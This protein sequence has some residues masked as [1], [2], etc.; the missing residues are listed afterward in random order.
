MSRVKDEHWETL[1]ALNDEW[2]QN[3]ELQL[4][5][6]Y[7]NTPTKSTETIPVNVRHSRP[8]RVRAAKKAVAAV[9]SVSR[10]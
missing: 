6:L 1:M 3:A 7:G 8:K 2:M 9:G 10:Y 5:A 4:E